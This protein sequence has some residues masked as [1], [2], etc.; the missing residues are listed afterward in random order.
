MVVCMNKAN[1]HLDVFDFFDL[2]HCLSLD[3]DDIIQLNIITIGGSITGDMTVLEN[4]D[5]SWTVLGAKIFI[6][7][8]DSVPPHQRDSAPHVQVAATIASPDDGNN[9]RP[10]PDFARM[11]CNGEELVEDEKTLAEYGVEDDSRINFAVPNSL[12]ADLRK[13]WS[14]LIEKYPED[15]IIKMSA[16]ASGEHQRDDLILGF[17]MNL[18]LK[19]NLRA[20][21]ASD[22]LLEALR[23]GEEVKNPVKNK[24][25]IGPTAM[26]N[27]LYKIFESK[28]RP[29]RFSFISGSGMDG[30]TEYMGFKVEANKTNYRYKTCYG[31]PVALS[32]SNR[33]KQSRTGKDELGGSRICYSRWEENGVYKTLGPSRH[34]GMQS[35]NKVW[36]R[37]S[38]HYSGKRRCCSR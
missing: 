13:V 35:E 17:V 11:F 7:G 5:V 8:Q 4:L 1:A 23:R 38:S 10:H 29:V 26:Q 24:Q 33:I 30:K 20:K 2:V 37:D 28:A 16:S 22:C 12:A 36:S 21:D 15:D 3:D 18:Y 31:I 25:L 34:C 6:Q 9:K 19:I 32:F 27:E 14:T